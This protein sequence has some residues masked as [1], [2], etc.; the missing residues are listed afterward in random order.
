[1]IVF[2]YY[3]TCIISGLVELGAILWGIGQGYS[4][5]ASLGLAIAY[6][7]GNIFRFFISKKFN[8]IDTIF[9]FVIFLMSICLFFVKE[10]RIT[11]YI[12][13]LIIFSLLSTVLQNMRSASQGNVPRWQKRSF[14]VFGFLLSAIMYQYGTLL[15][16]IILFVMFFL[17]F[18]IPD[19]YY[20]HWIKK[21]VGGE[22]GKNKIC[23]AMVT[24]QAHYFTYTYIILMVVT[25]YFHNPLIATL[26]F[27]GNWIPYTITEPLIKLTKFKNW[28]GIVIG[29]HIFNAVILCSM[30][31]FIN[32]NILVALSLWILTGFGGGNVF[33][34]N[35]ALAKKKEYSSEVLLFSEQVGHMLGVV[36]ATIIVITGLDYRISLIIG[37]VFA[38]ITIMI[39]YIAL[40]K[41]N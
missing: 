6:Q 35:K 37:A 29:A 31:A 34:I 1:M 27:T 22:Y 41:T 32:V 13:A 25:L 3:L 4:I 11:S 2:T 40:K 28:L 12:L 24:H 8:R 10:N 18:F 5:T 14:R 23:W 39:V 33:C 7:T 19:F 15:L 30:Y 20:D 36:T 21:L 38:L 9:I 16:S 17:S 26:W